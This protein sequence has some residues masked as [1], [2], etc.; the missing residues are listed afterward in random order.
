MRTPRTLQAVAVLFAMTLIAAGCGGAGDDS[1]GSSSG[2]SVDPADCGLEE[3]EAATEPVEVTFWHVQSEADA[4]NLQ[5]LAD[6]F[7]ASQQ[8][9]RVKLVQQP[10]Y[11]DAM[12]KWQAGMTTGDQPDVAQMEETTVQRLVDSDST[13][14]VQ[15]CVEADDFDLSDFS[16]RSLEFYTVD[17]VLQSMAWN[18]SNV[19]LFYNKAD[20]VKAGLDPD[21]PPATLEQ[22]REYSQQLVDTG[23]TPHGLSLRIAPYFTEFWFAKEGQTLVDNA[24]G[25]QG[26]ATKAEID[27]ATGTELWTWWKDMV[28]SGLAVNIGTDQS[29][30]D[31]FLAIG[32]HQAAMTIEGNATLA[33]ID[34][35]LSSGA[36]TDIEL[37]LAPLPGLTEGGGVPIGDGSLWLSKA[38]SPEKRGA[39]WQWI[40][41]L[42]SKDA[43]VLWHTRK[44]AVPTRISVAEDPAVQAL[45]AEKPA[46]RVGYDQL[47][48]P[49]DDATAGSLIGPYQEVR[50]AVTNGIASMLGSG[51]SVQQALTQAQSD[52]DAAIEDY[53][54]RVGG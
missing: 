48:G 26:R 7:N 39:A 15:A 9:V 50:D 30:I 46:Y 35:A 1:S 23:V 14:P 24:N 44:G 18:V 51:A 38:S 27:S 10:S 29:T 17:D 42:V 21:K 19:A 25:R 41:F 45:W 22:V 49:V 47:Q 53:N 37:G 34:A 43:Q 33:R 52:A 2:P 5:E 54:T 6:Q 16:E 8:D 32:N 40:K 13:V 12:Q 36:W 3:L 28:D 11:P 4:T 31:H 20:F